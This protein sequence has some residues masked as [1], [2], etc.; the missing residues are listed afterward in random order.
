[1]LETLT[2]YIVQKLCRGLYGSVRV[3]SLEGD[4][5]HV[6]QQNFEFQSHAPS[7]KPIDDGNPKL[8]NDVRLGKI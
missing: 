3:E 5:E 7:W 1:M 8:K 6:F 4:A 2:R